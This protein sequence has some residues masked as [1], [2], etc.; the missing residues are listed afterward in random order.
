[1]QNKQIMKRYKHSRVSVGDARRVEIFK[2][3]GKV[4]LRK[5]RSFFTTA[6]AN[7]LYVLDYKDGKKHPLGYFWRLAESR[8]QQNRAFRDERI[9]NLYA[10]IC[11]TLHTAHDLINVEAEHPLPTLEN[12]RRDTLESCSMQDHYRF[13]VDTFEEKT[14]RC[15]FTITGLQ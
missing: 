13:N 11:N 3:N 8:F 1:M 9:R 6:E 2:K 14:L 7:F 15:V 4:Q 12:L 10:R 5:F